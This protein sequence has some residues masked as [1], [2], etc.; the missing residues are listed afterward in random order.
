MCIFD[1]LIMNKIQ[2]LLVEENFNL[3]LENRE[4]FLDQIRIKFEPFMYKS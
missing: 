4:L 2:T 3:S 1:L